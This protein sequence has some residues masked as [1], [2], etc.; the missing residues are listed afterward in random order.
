LLVA[1][2][3]LGAFLTRD[4]GGGQERIIVCGEERVGLA[5]TNITT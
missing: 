2:S 1:R 3:L 5:S 4:A